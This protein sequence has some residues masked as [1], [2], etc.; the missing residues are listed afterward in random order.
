[1]LR[2]QIRLD[3]S[4]MDQMQASL[5]AEQ[6]A[7]QN[8]E[9]GQAALTARVQALE[10]EAQAAAAAL[11]TERSQAAATEVD[12]RAALGAEQA[13]RQTAEAKKGALDLRVKALV[14]EITE[15]R[16]TLQARAKAAEENLASERSRAAAAEA[17]IRTALEAEQS[18]RQATEA[19]QAALATQLQILETEAGLLRDQIRLDGSV[20]DEMQAALSVERQQITAL[21]A[22]QEAAETQAQ[23][24]IEAERAARLKAEADLGEMIRQLQAQVQQAGQ[25]LEAYLVQ[26]ET[27]QSERSALL[28]QIA[29]LRA[30]RADLE[31]YYDQ[32]KQVSDQVDMLTTDLGGLQQALKIAQAEAAE[33]GQH[34]AWLE[35]EISRI[36]RSRS[37]RLTTPL[38]KLRTSIGGTGDNA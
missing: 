22:A 32:A 5:A 21:Q 13:A 26:V 15:L 24:R 11:A 38:R 30:A 8:A 35:G 27:L 4:F 6:E 36:Y 23:S 29:Q 2:D 7:R 19:K 20:M 10:A 16:V 17:A 12:I 9:A 1:M 33:R 3:G 14:A 28:A 18:A 37:Y 31:G 34:V 25:E